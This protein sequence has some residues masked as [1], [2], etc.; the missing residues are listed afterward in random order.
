MEEITIYAWEFKELYDEYKNLILERDK[1]KSAYNKLSLKEKRR[2][3]GIIIIP[4]E[5]R[6]RNIMYN[7]YDWG[8]TKFQYAWDYAIQE[9]WIDINE[10]YKW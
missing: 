7:K 2:G 10:N 5:I 9:K 4:L 1:A 8:M 6:L 3:G